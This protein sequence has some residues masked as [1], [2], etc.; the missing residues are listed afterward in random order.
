MKFHQLILFT[1]G[2]ITKT[3]AFTPPHLQTKSTLHTV[4]LTTPI[5]QF[6]TR[7]FSENAKSSEAAETNNA[8]DADPASGEISEAQ[9]LKM[10]AQRARLEADKLEATLTLEKLSELEKKLRLVIS[11]NE[12]RDE[13]KLQ[14]E[15][16]AKRMDPTFV[17]RFTTPVTKSS[18]KSSESSVVKPQTTFEKEKTQDLSPD[19]TPTEL[20]EAYQAFIKLP[21]PMQI[22]LA[23]A[24][25][26]YVPKEVMT[27]EISEEILQKLNQQQKILLKDE[28]KLEA[29]Y[30][31]TLLRS[32]FSTTGLKVED[33]YKEG[34]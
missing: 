33:G 22:A 13:I 21:I 15:Q 32:N 4:P 17:P 26:S 2:V 16:L 31:E 24:V 12:S 19:L 34:E 25:D 8:N 20:Y 23:K 3:H 27:R 6:Q 5:R 11:N 10:Q 9:A 18:E 28:K 14:I 1:A 7:H 29:V 30:K